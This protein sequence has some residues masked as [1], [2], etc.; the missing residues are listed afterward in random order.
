MKF[1]K[2]EREILTVVHNHMV[3]LSVI[4][5]LL[6]LIL[7]TTSINKKLKYFLMIEPFVSIVLTFG[8]IY[9]L[10]SGITWFKYIIII[11][12]TFMT[13]SFLSASM[14]V[15]YQILFSKNNK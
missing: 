4:F 3:S 10:W 12:G 8:G 6:G 13:L 14:L 7:S 15:V 11:S 5:F 1:K 2:N 9:L